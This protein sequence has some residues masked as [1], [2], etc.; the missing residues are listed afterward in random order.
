MKSLRKKFKV[1]HK[2]VVFT[3]GVFD[4][5]HAGHVDYLIKA[6]AMGDILIVGM[7]SD[8]S[9]KRIKGEK[10]PLI[11]QTER[12]FVLSNLKP[13]DFVVIFEEDTPFE[14]IKELIP[15][16]LVKGADWS[17]DKIVGSDIITADGGEVKN[18]QFVSKQSTSKIIEIIL[19]RYSD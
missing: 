8:S 1:E 3:N 13:V 9:V 15:D 11:N 10:R 14:L 7:N 12:A 16:V 5:I 6:K 2:K 17:L 19:S 18:I 4:L